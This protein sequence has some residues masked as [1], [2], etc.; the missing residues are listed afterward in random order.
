MDLRDAER[1]GL[2]GV[3]TDPAHRRH[4]RGTRRKLS[5]EPGGKLVAAASLQWI[6]AR[7]P[8]A[9][10]RQLEAQAKASGTSRSD[11]I[12][13]CLEVGIEAIRLREGVPEGRVDDLVGRLE[14]ALLALDIIGP[15]TLGM[16]RLLAHWATQD[17]TVKV[18]EDEVVAEVRAVGAEEW[19]QAIAEGQR[20]ADQPITA[21]TNEGR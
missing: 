10:V 20:A 16:L 8:Q 3:T 15:S 1:T 14:N 21:P 11:A 2:A 12:R 13:D 4:S 17:G 5:A 18:G 9:L 6:T 19:D 7:V